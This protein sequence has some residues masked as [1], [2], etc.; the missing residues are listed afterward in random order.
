MSAS[1]RRR[2]ASTAC[3]T[4]L[5]PEYVSGTWPAN[6]ADNWKGSVYIS[7]NPNTAITAF[8]AGTFT[9]CTYNCSAL[10]DQVL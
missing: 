7:V 2:P 4:E 10:I 6:T 5:I 8:T 3:R 9:G 1:A